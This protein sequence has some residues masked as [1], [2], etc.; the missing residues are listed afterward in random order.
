[1]SPLPADRAPRH[2]PRPDD[3]P[4]H[5]G[6]ARPPPLLQPP[7]TTPC[8]REPRGALSEFTETAEY[9]TGYR[10][11]RPVSWARTDHASAS[12]LRRRLAGRRHDPHRG[13][14][15]RPRPALVMHKHTARP[16]ACSAVVGIADGA[17]ALD[18]RA[19]SRRYGR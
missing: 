13:R 5:P 12:H 4:G 3:R 9:A 7:E 17:E 15:G 16:P 1:M 14:S 10:G 18:N 6:P 11:I 19:P 2:P 8:I